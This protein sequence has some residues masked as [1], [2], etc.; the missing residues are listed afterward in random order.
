MKPL[1]AILLFLSF[2]ANAQQKFTVYF[3]FNSAKATDASNEKLLQWIDNNKDAKIEKIYG[4]ADKSGNE[5]YN[6]DLSER[7][8]L[9]VYKQLKSADIMLNNVEE[10]SF[11]ESLS[12][13]I[14]KTDRKVEI[15]YT[16]NIDKVSLKAEPSVTNLTRLFKEAKVG[17]KIVLKDIYFAG[18]TTYILKE[19]RPALKEFYEIM[20]DNPKLK[21]DLQGHICCDTDDIGDLSGK[22]AMEIYLY[23]NGSGIDGKRMQ[24]HG[25]GGHKPIHSIPEWNNEEKAENRRVEVEILEK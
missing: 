22:R 9:Y 3:N 25:F 14:S 2:S 5:T 24:A 21:I 12:S 11:G 6:Q 16:K 23:L 15:Y 7:R 17:D 10:K 18:G 19:S 20:N 8:A 13:R 1:L 4:Y